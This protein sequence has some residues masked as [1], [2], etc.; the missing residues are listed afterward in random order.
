MLVYLTY[1]SSL[2]SVVSPELVTCLVLE[3]YLIE[4]I[5]PES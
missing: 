3:R 1:L 4:C 2:L 5:A